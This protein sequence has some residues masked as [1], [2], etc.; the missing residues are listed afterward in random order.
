LK[1]KLTYAV[2]IETAGILLAIW[3]IARLFM[4]CWA[5]L[6]FPLP[7]DDGEGHVLNMALFI[8]HGKLPYLPINEPPYI[9]TNYPPVFQ[10]ISALIYPFTRDMSIIPGVTVFPGLIVDRMISI[11]S[12]I[13]IAF[14][15]YKTSTKLKSGSTGAAISSMLFIAMP[16]VYFWLPIGKPDMLAICLGLLGLYTAIVNIDRGN[17]ILISLVFLI[18]ALFTKQN[19]VAPFLGILLF[20]IIKRDR[21]WLSF[22]LFYL[23]AIAAIAGVLEIATQGEF[24]KHVTIYTRTQFYFERLQATWG[25]FAGYFLIPLV[26][27]LVTTVNAFIKRSYN[28]VH[29]YFIFA[30][31]V[32][33][34]SGKVGSD[35]NYFIESI[36]AG[37]IVLALCL[38]DWFSREG[39]QNQVNVPSGSSFRLAASALIFIIA[40]DYSFIHDKRIYSYSPS[41]DDYR[42][43]GIIVQEI[44]S[45]PG[46]VL[47]EDEGFA[48]VCGKEVLFNPFIM[49]ELAKEGLWDQ[50][51]FVNMIK[52]KRFDLIILRFEVTSPNHP[53][54]PSRGGYAG[55]DRWTEEMEK[56]IRENY[57]RYAVIPMR[58]S[59][60]LYLPLE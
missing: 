8:S 14:L 19:E 40:L 1:T 30:L 55:W 59:W 41:S 6:C 39:V 15:I 54:K 36:I 31:L 17:R 52:E 4:H 5:Y 25:F 57:Y 42:N 27:T 43:G 18:M 48:V 32:S 37:H 10:S 12:G 46:M 45:K 34:T 50:S 3:A 38:G 44:K 47:S 53:D 35:M 7:L 16:I 24:L 56:A 20:L 21:R 51:D 26:V 11:M 33:L 13:A 58:R 29:F 22:L 60:Y 23:I 28:P 9:V 2:I 49:S